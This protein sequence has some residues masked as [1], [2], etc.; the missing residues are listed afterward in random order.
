MAS[1]ENEGLARSSDI[2]IGELIAAPLKAAADAQVDLAKST[3]EFIR[4]VG[5]EQDGTGVDKVRSL[6]F[7]LSAMGKDGAERNLQI[8][9]PLL[10]IVP[11]PNLAVEEVDIGFQ[12]EVTSATRNSTEGSG[13]ES[14]GVSVCG[15]VSSQASNT[16]ETNQSA[17]YQ[18]QVKA[19]KQE[20]P[21]G[22]SRILDIMAQSVQ[23]S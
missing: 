15:Q 13:S 4:T 5:L 10:A 6:N 17:K 12:M 23:G 18:I 20:M 8:Q 16:R 7:N 21:E 1:K 19:R 9:A 3:V 2:S 14:Q 22:L 11:I